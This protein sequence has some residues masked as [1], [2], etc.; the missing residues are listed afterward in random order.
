MH[1]GAQKL[2]KCDAHD[3]VFPPHDLA[4]KRFEA[5]EG[6]PTHL[7]FVHAVDRVGRKAGDGKIL[8]IGLKCTATR[9]PQ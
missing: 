3:A 6:E 9:C 1:D 4:L 8:H 2:F 7:T 5:G